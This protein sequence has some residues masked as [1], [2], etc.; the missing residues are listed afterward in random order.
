MEPSFDDVPEVVDWMSSMVD[1][2]GRASQESHRLFLARRTA[3]EMLRDRG[4][5]VPE[6]ELARTLPEFRAWWAQEPEIERLSFSTFLA[7]DHSDKVK[8]LFCPPEPVRIANIQEIHDQIEGENLSRLILILLGKI[9]PRAKES[10]KEKFTFKVD[11]FQVNELLVNI[12]KHDLKPKHEVLT[13]EEKAKLLKLYNVEDSQERR[14]VLWQVAGH[15]CDQCVVLYASCRAVQS[16]VCQL[17]N[18]PV[19]DARMTRRE[20]T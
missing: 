2:G 10:V 7:S 19:E 5:S 13:A 8:I 15:F 11:I 4:Y 3:L 16:W 6:S 17:V 20:G 14:G 12:S 18:S 9:M 1:R